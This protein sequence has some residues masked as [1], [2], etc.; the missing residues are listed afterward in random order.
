LTVA[1]VSTVAGHTVITL[2]S[3]LTNVIASGAPISIPG[4]VLQAGSAIS[5]VLTNG[6][7]QAIN[8][9]TLFTTAA[10]G[11]ATSTRD[12]VQAGAVKAAD[13][14][15]V[16][17][18]ADTTAAN[19][20][21]SSTTAGVS[22]GAVTSATS[23]SIV[24]TISVAAGT[25]AN[26]NVPVVITDG[27]QTFKDTIAIVAGITATSVSTVGTVSAGGGEYVALYGT[28]FD[29]TAGNNTISVWNN[30][31]VD[32]G[33]V[34]TVTAAT[35]TVLTVHVTVSATSTALNGTDSFMVTEASADGAGSA[36]LA[37]AVVISGQP[38][39]TAVSPTVINSITSAASPTMTITGTGFSTTAGND[40]ISAQAYTSTGA[41]DGA[42]Q[43]F[44]ASAATATSITAAATSATF[45]A[46]DTVKFTVTVSGAG[47]AV[48]PAITVVAA[49]SNLA[50]VAGGSI[51]I[52]SKS[53][54]FVISGAGFLAGATVSFA[55]TSGISATTASVTPNSVAG[56]ITVPTSVA[57]GS[58]TA[59]VTNANGGSATVSLTVSA[60]P[61]LTGFTSTAGAVTTYAGR[62]GASGTLTIYGT[63]F[64]ST[65]AAATLPVFSVS[66]AIATFGAAT[67]VSATE[68]TV[69][70]TY[71]S[72]TGSSALSGTIT[73][74]YPSGDGSATG[75]YL[76][77]NPGPIVTGT[78][79][80]PTQSTSQ[81][82][83]ITGSGFE[84]GMTAAIAGTGYSA[85]L[86]SVS[87]TKAVLIVT[88]T[89]VATSGTY[90]V[91]TFTNPDGGTA[92]FN[93][94][95]GTPSVTPVSLT[96]TAVAGSITHGKSS[97]VT[98]SGTGFYGQPT[99]KSSIAGVTAK[100]AKDNGMTLTVNV[101]AS[102]SAKKGAGV[103]T[104]TLAN[105]TS[106]TV[107]Y[108]L[109]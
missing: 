94:N 31:A 36:V 89:A 33:V 95:G 100:V 62:S 52:G 6:A 97:V 59:T 71:L 14:F 64:G 37:N 20:T 90:A 7:G 18:V 82:V 3:N 106:T 102:A 53:V 107:K 91:V 24:T 41:T 54:P 10:N 35:A 99:V 12:S 74:V 109:K 45:A 60:Q 11:T 5:A 87:A 79:Y 47:A 92:T 68:I 1:S 26:S 27:V 72:Y 55:S 50:F 49:P 103:F 70:V 17:G 16:T 96:A 9:T 108:T 88:T 98:I 15:T 34:A 80:V 19:W 63:G 2:S 69:P 29:T 85:V 101:A 4:E 86:G 51:A 21:V 93:L 44:T 43:T 22:F 40:T 104:I 38:T 81:E 78:Y 30:G 75:L 48:S 28:N 8:V 105:G 84:A 67:W 76:T 39:V 46:G 56:T 73:A 25:A 42:A 61:T 23:T 57:A 83:D 65:A 66:P 32:A 58:Y 13:T 77:V